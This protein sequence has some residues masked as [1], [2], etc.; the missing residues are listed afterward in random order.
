[1]FP[2]LFERVTAAS[3]ANAGPLAVR[4]PTC[5]FATRTMKTARQG[6]S[7]RTAF[8][9]AI[10][11][12][13]HVQKICED[14]PMRIAA[15][16]HAARTM[17]AEDVKRRCSAGVRKSLYCRVR[18]CGLLAAGADCDA[19]GAKMFPF[20]AAMVCASSGGKLPKLIV[21]LISR[22]RQRLSR[23][24]NYY[25]F[26]GRRA[27]AVQ[28]ARESCIHITCLSHLLVSRMMTPHAPTTREK[29]SHS[30]A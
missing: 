18:S 4:S 9:P 26:Q 24:L 6:I 19:L 2:T 1:M 11:I 8:M 20:G 13:N 5:M 3:A 23:S 7:R 21:L 27:V 22:D 29:P 28:P 12:G 15:S 16:Q 10:P 14:V 25:Q 17:P 30:N